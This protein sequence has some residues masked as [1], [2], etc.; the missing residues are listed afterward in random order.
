M[1]YKWSDTVYVLYEMPPVE[2][3][4]LSKLKPT[5][6]KVETPRSL[7]AVSDNWEFNIAEGS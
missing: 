6:V 5:R 3:R 7:G 1:W 2:G 4:W